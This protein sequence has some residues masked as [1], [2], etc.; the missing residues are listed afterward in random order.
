MKLRTKFS[1]REEETIDGFLQGISQDADGE[2]YLFI[3]PIN[4]G[5]GAKV[6]DGSKG[7]K[8]KLK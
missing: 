3:A 2:L 4:T 6:F 1:G 8:Y 7:K 5:K